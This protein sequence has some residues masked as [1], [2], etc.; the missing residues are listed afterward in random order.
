VPATVGAGVNYK[1]YKRFER[2]RKYTVRYKIRAA[3]ATS[4]I[5]A[6]L[7][8]AGATDAA[9]AGFALSSTWTER[10]F[11]WTPTADR[12]YGVLA[13]YNNAATAAT[14]QID[15]V[16][17][18]PA[19]NPSQQ[20]AASPGG[21]EPVG[22]LP[23]TAGQ[24]ANITLTADADA[25][26]G[27][28]ADFTNNKTSSIAWTIDPSLLSPDDFTEDE[29]HL[30]VWAR[31]RLGV[32]TL[33]SPRGIVFA[34]NNFV[35]R[36]TQEYGEIGAAMAPPIAVDGANGSQYG[37]A[38]LGTLLFSA[39]EL[40]GQ[41]WLLTVMIQ[42]AGTGTPGLD[43]VMLVPARS[44]A[45][46]PTNK[47]VGNATGSETYPALFQS[48]FNYSLVKKIKWDL[49]TVAR[50]ENPDAGFGGPSPWAASH[51]V[52]GQLLEYPPG[53]VLELVKVTDTHLCWSVAPS[54]PRDLRQRLSL[55][56]DFWPR[57]LLMR[58]D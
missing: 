10:S 30:E 8:N 32:T 17:V 11:T 47:P 22:L 43:Y 7:G 15:S 37:L 45:A 54:N 6:K 24:L 50:R 51:G 56:H 27:T 16:V 35:S 18:E 19:D 2:G 9:S 5:N 21:L 52:G 53:A 34:S 3:S 36:Y 25:T 12:D 46:T 39:D 44:R 4:T 26:Q 38:R 33:V 1:I 28:R 23:A 55:K 58:A 29:V 40:V 49:S 31:I 20:S 14:Y 41:P 57:Y 42:W 13:F 48:N